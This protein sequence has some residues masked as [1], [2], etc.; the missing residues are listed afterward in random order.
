MSSRVRVAGA[1]HIG[2]AVENLSLGGAF[3]RC[4]QTPALKTHASLEVTV[5]GALQPLVLHGKVAYAVSPAEAQKKKVSPG[6]AIEFTQP[7][8]HATK[9]GLERLLSA[10]DPEAVL[11]VQPLD[12]AHGQSVTLP[13][14]EVPTVATP[15]ASSELDALRT[16][17]AAQEREIARLRD[18]NVKLKDALRLL[19]A[20]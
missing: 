4:A 10:V 3:V 18:E 19:R 17:V 14:F 15:P 13:E 7:L 16:R 6:F 1:L 9:L 8:P 20:R 12:D 11:L 5:P 2:L